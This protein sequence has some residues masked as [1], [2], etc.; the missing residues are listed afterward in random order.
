MMEK[1]K[2]IEELVEI[3]QTEVEINLDTKLD[4]IPEWDSLGI[5]STLAFLENKMGVKCDMTS[6]AAQKTVNDLYE[7][8]KHS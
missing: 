7:M 3:L 4:E 6:L 5:M 1:E 8:G 2:F